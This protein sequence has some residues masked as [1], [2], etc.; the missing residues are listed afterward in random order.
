MDSWEGQNEID[1]MKWKGSPIWVDGGYGDLNR[2]V[3]GYDNLDR[4][5]W[6]RGRRMER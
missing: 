2:Q 1:K 4:R 5:G 6:C 3:C